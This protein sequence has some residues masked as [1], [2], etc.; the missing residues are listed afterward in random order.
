MS[1]LINY[2][3]KVTTLDGRQLI[4][5]LLSF[6]KHMNLVLAECEEFRITKKSLINLKKQHVEL[7]K[8]NISR[9]N[10]SVINEDKRALGLIIL[11]G[12]HVVSLSIEAP[13][14]NNNANSALSGGPI[15]TNNNG[16]TPRK[17]APPP[18]FKRN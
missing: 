15:R 3:I 16:V 7:M 8:N 2:R 10:E 6:D 17:F 9:I 13:P 4:G 5:T 1:D 11:R 14:T 18:G 12:E